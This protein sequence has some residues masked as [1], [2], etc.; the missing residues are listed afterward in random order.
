MKSSDKGEFT[1][2]FKSAMEVYDKALS[3]DAL[4]I[5]WATM[6]DISIDDFRQ[7][8]TRHITTSQ[9]FPKPS[10]ILSSFRKNDKPGAEEAWAM[11]PKGED[12]SVVWT[13]DMAVA[14][15]AA[16]PLMVDGDMI[17]ARMAFKEVYEREL[18]KNIPT[19]WITS[20][21]RDKSGREAAL[22][23]AVSQK[24][25]SLETALKYMPESEQ[26]LQLA[27][28]EKPLLENQTKIKNLLSG[29]VVEKKEPLP[30][31][32]DYDESQ[33]LTGKEIDSGNQP[34]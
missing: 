21:G 14:F 1:A 33:L 2:I 30:W 5:W 12:D 8:M 7:S 10:D 23:D 20:F 29:L 16:S 26:L 11:I 34:E 24:R 25:L 31:D 4:N 3:L 32:E 18:A 9:Y 27:N 22:Q 13:Q 17:G 6:A 19:K 15:G 28:N